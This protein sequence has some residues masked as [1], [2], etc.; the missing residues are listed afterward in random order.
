MFGKAYILGL[1]IIMVITVASCSGGSIGFIPDDDTAPVIV[2]NGISDGDQYGTL[3]AGPDMVNTSAVAA[4]EAGI[5]SFT[6]RID[7]ALVASSDDGNLDYTWDAVAAG[8][9]MHQLK[10]TAIDENG[11]MSEA[12][13]ESEVVNWIFVPF[14]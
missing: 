12:T 14:P 9:G 5:A 2:I 8:N 10:W 7:G 1:A 13:I 6:L 11:N 3:V 4:D